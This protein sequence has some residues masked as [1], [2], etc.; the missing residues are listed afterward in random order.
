MRNI[1]SKILLT[2]IGILGC[3]ISSNACHHKEKKETSCTQS[4][5]N[6]K[7]N[8]EK[9]ICLYGTPKPGY[10]PVES[11]QSKEKSDNKKKESKSE[12]KSDK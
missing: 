7:I 8:N 3:S 5:S 4:K 6:V 11:Q 9:V 2:L 1:I 12:K 10:K